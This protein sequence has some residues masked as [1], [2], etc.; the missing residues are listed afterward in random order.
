VGSKRQ[1]Q[2]NQPQGA[3]TSFRNRTK[4]V[5]EKVVA[6]LE[7]HSRSLAVAAVLFA[8]LR[9]VATYH[10]FD[11]T[12]DEPAHI[13]CG[14]EY[15]AEG[16][17]TWEPQ[18]PPLS[19][20]AIA[21]GPYLMGLR[22]QNTPRGEYLALFHEGVNI[23]YSGHRYEL[24]LSLARA[25][26]LP[27]FW[28]ACLVVYLWGVRYFSH[29]VAAAAVFF[30]SFLPP[31]LAHSG[32][33]TTDIA[34]TAFLAAAYLAGRVWLE[35]PSL[36]NGLLFGVCAGLMVLSK[37]S[38][39]AFFPASVALALVWYFWRERP[40]VGRV[41]TA[42]RERFPSFA[43]ALLAGCLVVWAGYR[44][45][46]GKVPFAS[47]RLPVPELWAGI[48]EVRR[49]NAKGHLCYLL[50]TVGGT[51]FWDFYLVALGVKT[52]LGFL[53]LLGVGIVLA[54]RK[55]P[56]ANELW[57]PL[58]FSTG[59]LLVGIFSRI[60]IGLR[61][62]L[63]VYVGFSL[64]AAVAA[65]HLLEAAGE[66]R[67]WVRAVP[68]VLCLWFAA[69]SLLAHPDYLAYFNE[70][71]GSEPE[72]ILVDSDL[73]WGQDQKRLGQRLRALGVTDVNY[74]P[75]IVG[76]L[77]REHG[78][79]RI[80]ILNRHSPLPG[81]NAVSMTV[82]KELRLVNWPDRFPPR[83]RVGK[84]MLLWYFPPPPGMPLVYRE[85]TASF[86]VRDRAPG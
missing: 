49:H 83:E 55:R 39:L 48:E 64:L 72:N 43:L 84:S 57:L 20:V 82:W 70:L 34:L 75:Y 54:F 46:F 41:L 38:C 74:S 24:G 16:T 2:R 45:S 86:T 79:P 52:P 33:A 1:K 28:L 19:R 37:F 18:H 42:A 53:A 67:R 73:D 15:L 50:G 58:A 25:G 44:F 71:A 81:W 32:L 5:S 4:P 30:F 77:E 85:F 56:P 47:F 23:L 31:V 66:A 10:V 22:P 29:A 6:F 68:A 27:F 80:H 60:N 11:H 62:V 61:H 63:P 9:I 69:S 35:R 40:K 8:S 36:A 7:G 17:Y 51:G 14:M 78:F 12:S 59:I 3:P 65:L 21:L 26:V 76:E 13:T